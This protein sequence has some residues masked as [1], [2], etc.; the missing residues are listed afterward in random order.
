LI[1]KACS[2]AGRPEG[3]QIGHAVENMRLESAL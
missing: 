1:R 3:V 2:E